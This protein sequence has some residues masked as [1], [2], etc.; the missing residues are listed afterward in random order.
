MTCSTCKTKLA[1][2]PCANRDC[3]HHV[4][5]NT[6]C[7]EPCVGCGKPLC[8]TRCSLNDELCDGCMTELLAWDGALHLELAA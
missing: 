4:C 8:L 1:V 3:D 2:A 6:E 7:A 5:G